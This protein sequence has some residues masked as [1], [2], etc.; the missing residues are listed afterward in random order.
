MGTALSLNSVVV[1]TET[2][3]KLHSTYFLE[4]AYLQIRKYAHFLILIFGVTYLKQC[5]SNSEK[6]TPV[7]PNLSLVATVTAPS[8]IPTEKEVCELL[9]EMTLEA[10]DTMP[11]FAN[12]R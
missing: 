1:Y 7:D 9:R 11:P 4:A 10:F 3:R 6:N 12:S 2:V 5:F 8:K